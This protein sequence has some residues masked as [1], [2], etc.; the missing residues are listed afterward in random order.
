MKKNIFI[1]IASAAA[2]LL[3]SACSKDND[4]RGGSDPY[5]DVNVQEELFAGIDRYSKLTLASDGVNTLWNPGDYIGLYDS[6]ANVV[7]GVLYENALT[8]PAAEARFTKK[9]GQSSNPKTVEGKY[10]AVAPSS[11]L[12]SWR[13]DVTA[14][15]LT[16]PATQK[17]NGPGE[18]PGGFPILYA[19]SATGWFQFKHALGY[20]SFTFGDDSPSDIVLVTVTN[21][22]D[23]LN[24]AGKIA[25][26]MINGE[27]SLVS[28]SQN[29]FAFDFSKKDGSAFGKGKYY[30]ALPPF[31]YKKGLKLTFTNANG[32]TAVKSIPAGS[33]M[34]AG[35]IQNIGTVANLTFGSAAPQVG[36]PYPST[37]TAVGMV[38]D[39]NT[40][41]STALVMSID[42]FK[43]SWSDS[44]HGSEIIGLPSNSSNSTTGP[45]AT[46]IVTDHFAELKAADPSLV[47]TT[48]YPAVGFCVSKGEG[49]FLPTYKGE[50][51]PLMTKLSLNTEAGM[52]DFNALLAK[53][54]GSSPLQSGVYYWLCS[55]KSSTDAS[56]GYSRMKP[57]DTT[58]VSGYGNKVSN[59]GRPARAFK[60][61]QYG[62]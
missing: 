12:Y 31:T 34:A 13:R 25:I 5:K 35:R 20:V 15:G 53:I 62:E 43:G 6:T 37:G 19:S 3:V 14:A 48:V 18:L 28:S 41:T 46:K 33:V 55:E 17:V 1:A 39:V 49:W 42:E 23:S 50:W 54:T 21:K 10:Y 40:A 38:V 16:L 29:S 56:A 22:D 11:A 44:A 9:D 24:L 57:N 58:G 47:I 27:F 45:A 51:S 30:F 52:N 36:D 60:Y 8:E 59:S 2:M 26:N 61:W 7:G 32:Q 4:R